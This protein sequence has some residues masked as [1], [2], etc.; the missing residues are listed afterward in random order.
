MKT[1][2][3]LHGMLMTYSTCD[4]VVL[5]TVESLEFIV[6]QFSWY[7]WVAFSHEFTYSLTEKNSERVIFLTETEI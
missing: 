3:W 6:V 4:S 5:H 2:F 7:S 1:V